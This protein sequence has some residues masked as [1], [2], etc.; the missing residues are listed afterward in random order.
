MDNIVTLEELERILE[1]KYPKKFHNIYESGAMEWLK[2]SYKWLD[3]NR[4]KVETNAESFFYGVGGDCEP[5]VFPEINN[6]ID[7]FEEM[8]GYDEEYSLGKI[9]I[10]VQQHFLCN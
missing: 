7:H 1:V 8:L 9:I 2:H 4:Q 6:F 3:Q 5:I 10:K